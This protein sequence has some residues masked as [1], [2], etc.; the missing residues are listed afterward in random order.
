V[1]DGWNTEFHCPRC[2]GD[3]FGTSDADRDDPAAWTGHC[4]GNADRPG[5][6]FAWPRSEDARY[7]RPTREALE[8]ELDALRAYLRLAE[9]VLA[10]DP[11]ALDAA[12][13]AWAELSDASRS[14]LNAYVVAT[15]GCRPASGGDRGEPA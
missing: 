9:G 10:G 6:G 11:E 5:C 13:D 1:A 8:A 14:A 15:T 7:F 12:D 3:H 2:G 4:H